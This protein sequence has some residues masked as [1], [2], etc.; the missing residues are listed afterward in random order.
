[1]FTINPHKLLVL[2]LV[3][4]SHIEYGLHLQLL[5]LYCSQNLFLSSLI[6]KENP[7]S[8]ISLLVKMIRVIM[9]TLIMKMLQSY[10][11]TFSLLIFNSTNDTIIFF[12]QMLKYTCLS[13]DL[14][15][16]SH[17]FICIYFFFEICN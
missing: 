1:M 9:R 12:K 2:V 4:L 5:T 14:G 17:N 13:C 6:K 15:F 16:F 3:L 7:L 11:S 8:F 10:T